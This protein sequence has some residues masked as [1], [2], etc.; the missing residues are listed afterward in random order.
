MV[1]V[2]GVIDTEP[3]ISNVT[4]KFVINV[5]QV[6]LVGGTEHVLVNTRFLITTKLYPRYAYGDEIDLTGKIILPRN[7]GDN[8][9]KEGQDDT[10]AEDETAPGRQFDYV[11]YLAKDQIYFLMKSPQV[12]LLETNKGSRIKTL[13]FQFKELFL[14]NIK[15]VLGEPHASLAGGLVAGEKSALGKDLLVDFRR[16]GLI[17]IVI[18]SGYSVSIIA[19]SIRRML[20]FLP[21]TMNLVIAGIGMILFSILVGAGATVVRACIMA[22]FG[23]SAQLAYRDYSAMRALFITAY[24]MAVQ[25]PSIVVYDSSFQISFL[26][27]FGLILL[28][29]KIW[30]KLRF[31]P[32]R[33]GLRELVASTLATQ[34][35]VAPLL[36][37]LMGNASLVGVFANILVLPFIPLTMLTVFLTGMAGFVSASISMIIAAGAFCLLGYELLIVE[38]FARLPYSNITLE[39]FSLLMMWCTYGFYALVFLYFNYFSKLVQNWSRSPPS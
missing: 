29:R 10:L 8:V 36:L 31:V 11:H 34:I 23:I 12:T 28:G 32:E 15:R 22:L 18:L 30:Q 35:S 25:N 17:H 2:R 20:S 38:F 9:Q 27:T 39:S 19:A 3:E 4:Q 13:L 14:A 33:F 16:S 7:F 24:L 37:Y 26:A 1:T 21:R 6:S 5:E